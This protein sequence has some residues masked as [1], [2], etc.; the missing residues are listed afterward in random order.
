MR[1]EL[2]RPIGYALS[3]GLARVTSQLG[4]GR[5]VR[6]EAH[7]GVDYVCGTSTGAI[8]AAFLAREP[9][10]WHLTAARFWQAVASDRAINSVWRST[11]RSL[12]SAASSRTGGLIRK[13]LHTAFADITFAELELPLIVMATDITTG[14]AIAIDEGTVV[15]AVLASC[16][17]PVVTPP[18]AHGD[19]LL[20]DG[21]MI[22]GVPVN[23]LI[24]AGMKS[25]VVFDTGSSAVDTAELVDATWYEV[26]ALA[27]THM[28]RVQ[29][30][31]DLTLA[32]REVP[33]VRI[34]CATG[35]PFNLRASAEMIEPG[36]IAAR[37]TLAELSGARQGI[38]RLRKP[39]LYPTHP[40][41]N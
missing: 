30:E 13:H 37:N 36:A 41:G 7:L 34:A 12:S 23:P 14:T 33:V 29:A 38:T 16:S 27:T 20:V 32:A 8:N 28:L 3:G 17:F 2:P 39:G 11:M 21:S 4:M 5:V 10:T 40:L 18:L 31:H 1:L 35:S 19:Q 9:A 26:M 25:I 6:H 22:A 15:E 24:A